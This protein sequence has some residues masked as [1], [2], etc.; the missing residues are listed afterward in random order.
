MPGMLTALLQ[1]ESNH[2]RTKGYC[3]CQF[4]DRKS[5]KRPKIKQEA[6]PKKSRLQAL[7]AQQHTLGFLKSLSLIYHGI[8]LSTMCQGQC[9]RTRK[10]KHSLASAVGVHA[11]LCETLMHAGKRQDA[12][13]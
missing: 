11:P 13:Y 6:I 12:S 10:A 9:K 4:Q 7:F 3:T 1:N 8:D 2:S 5:R